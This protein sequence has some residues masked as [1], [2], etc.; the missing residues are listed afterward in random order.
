[1]FRPTRLI[2]AVSTLWAQL[3]TRLQLTR[4]NISFHLFCLVGGFFLGNI[5]GTFLNVLRGIFHWD[6]LIILAFIFLCEFISFQTYRP[7]AEAKTRATLIRAQESVYILSWRPLNLI[8]LGLL[9]GFFVDAFK[10][11]S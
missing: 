10:V 1:M 7:I 4:E 9:F 6:G 5:F 2:S 8:K 11:G 3:N